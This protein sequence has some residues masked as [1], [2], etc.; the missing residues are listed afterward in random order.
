MKKT[1]FV[2]ALL[3]ILSVLLLPA[4][5]TDNQDS[6]NRSGDNTEDSSGMEGSNVAN[7]R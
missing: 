7:G 1:R 5:G 2:I 4:C 6:A 3:L